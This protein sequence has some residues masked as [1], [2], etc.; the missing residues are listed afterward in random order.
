MPLGCQLL[1]CF[2]E[3]T[4]ECVAHEA[5]EVDGLLPMSLDFSAVDRSLACRQQI[6]QGSPLPRPHR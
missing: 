5:R 4:V 2:N 1:R 6:L 3:C